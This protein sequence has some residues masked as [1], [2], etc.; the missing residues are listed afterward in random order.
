M[1]RVDGFRGAVRDYEKRLRAEGKATETL[2]DYLYAVER[3][4]RVLKK[5]GRPPAP[6]R[7]KQEHIQAILQAFERDPWTLRTIAVCL[8]AMGCRTPIRVRVPERS[9]VRWLSPEDAN[10]VWDAANALGPPWSTAIFL[11]LGLGFRRKSV[12]EARTA[13]FM[14]PRVRV[15]GKSHDYS[16]APPPE[17]QGVLRNAQEWRKANG[18][19]ACG[20]LIPARA[21]KLHN[22]VK[23]FSKRGMDGLLARVSLESG[24]RFSNHDL[25]RS[26]GKRLYRAGV[27][28]EA[29]SR[30]MGHRSVSQT[31]TYLG[32]D[33]EDDLEAWAKLSE[34]AKRPV[35][36]L[37]SAADRER[38]GTSP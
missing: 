24:V 9:R 8:R 28:L 23:T 29:I 5:S 10:R 11:E 38:T 16:F 34:W 30:L 37:D 15:R 12:C 18:L 13:D 35:L 31:Y 14:G 19:E 21:R 25:R 4:Y 26:F 3:A 33:M 6:R 27:R 17:L 36:F 1:P 32:L 7:L 22:A 20:I 2:R